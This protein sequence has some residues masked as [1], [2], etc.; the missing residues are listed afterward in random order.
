MVHGQARL[1]R[2]EFV[3]ISLAQFGIEMIHGQ[4][5]LSRNES[6]TPRRPECFGSACF[7]KGHKG[8][9]AK[10]PDEQGRQ[11][12]TYPSTYVSGYIRRRQG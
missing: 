5:R 2:N 12:R 3:C 9:E 4:A 6:T 10:N 11:C 8:R 1:S 7:L